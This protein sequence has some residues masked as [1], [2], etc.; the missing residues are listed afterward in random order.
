MHVQW[1][2]R[3][4]M[5][6]SLRSVRQA[7][8]AA[9]VCAPGP[10]CWRTTGPSCSRTRRTSST[11]RP[12]RTARPTSPG[13]GL[14]PIPSGPLAS[15]SPFARTGGQGSSAWGV[16]GVAELWSVL[17]QEYIPQLRRTPDST[18]SR[19]LIPDAPHDLRNVLTCESGVLT[20]DG[21]TR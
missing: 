11:T 9:S 12:A 21:P 15:C 2:L 14:E 3:A 20:F 6:A 7:R 16:R 18:S 1:S 19:P 10:T 17:V 4:D 8:C 13:R 5:C